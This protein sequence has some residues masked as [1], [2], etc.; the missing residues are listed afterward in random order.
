MAEVKPLKRTEIKGSEKGVEAESLE[1]LRKLGLSSS[2][3]KVY[4]LLFRCGE[5][6]V[7]TIS[8]ISNVD[9]GETYRVMAKLLDLGLVEKVIDSP[10]R[11]RAVSLAEGITILLERKKKEDDEVL[12]KAEKMLSD[13]ALPST[14]Q[15]EDS[16]EGKTLMVPP[17]DH[18][19]SLLREK[20]YNIQKSYDV[21]TFL[22]ELDRNLK[23]AFKIYQQLLNQGVKI[24]LIVENLEKRQVSSK[25]LEKLKQS[26]NFQIKYAFC[27]VPACIG[28]YDNREVRV[29]IAKKLELCESAAFWSNMPVFVSLAK[30]YFDAVW[31]QTNV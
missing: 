9:R 19:S 14:E 31:N 2:Q 23:S 6:S 11:F 27:G 4:L 15:E 26:P 29:S 16:G 20:L 22:D 28:L 1:T 18:L 24:R 21:I 8:R 10:I 17:G 7:N 13:A 5:A 30:G 25:L 12:L 3:S